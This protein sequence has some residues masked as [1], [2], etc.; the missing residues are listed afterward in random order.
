M[1]RATT[2]GEARATRGKG[3]A[4][5][6]VSRCSFN[7]PVLW[8]LESWFFFFF[9]CRFL[10]VLNSSIFPT[11]FKS[12]TKFSL[13]EDPLFLLRI[14]FT[15]L[16]YWKIWK[17]YY[18]SFIFSLSHQVG[19]KFLIISWFCIILKEKGEKKKILNHFSSLPSPSK[20]NAKHTT[21]L[22]QHWWDHWRNSLIQ[23]PCLLI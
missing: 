15:P 17:L 10:L 13:A 6:V 9:F 19:G 22:P 18:W 21:Y 14:H 3:L 5:G 11:G 20:R 23:K 1:G 16:Y 4:A 2:E 8:L 7:Y 12:H